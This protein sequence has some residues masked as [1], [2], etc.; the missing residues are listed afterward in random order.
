[1]KNKKTILIPGWMNG[2]GMYKCGGNFYNVLEIWKERL[3]KKNISTGYIIAH[4]LGCNWALRN[5]EGSKNNKFILVNPLLPKRKIKKWFRSWIEFYRKETLP[6][7]K[8]V[9]SGFGNWIFGMKE[10]WKL[11]R[12]DFD[13]ILENIPKENI[14]VICGKKDVF[15]CDKKMKEYVRSK[16]IELME[17]ENV[18]HDWC[19]EFYREI[20]K[21]IQ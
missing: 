19:R 2:A 12:Y 6:K 5:L 10:C 18:G 4:S 11:L 14:V 16:N 1:M 13:E 8:D 9:I 15:Y 20:E 21:I 17:I 3:V 7:N